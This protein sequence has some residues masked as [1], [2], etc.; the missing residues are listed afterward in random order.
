VTL[1]LNKLWVLEPMPDY[2]SNWQ[3]IERILSHGLIIRLHI[4]EK[5]TLVIQIMVAIKPIV[6]LGFCIISLILLFPEW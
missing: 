6:K 5:R 2:K 4:D 3:V 1:E